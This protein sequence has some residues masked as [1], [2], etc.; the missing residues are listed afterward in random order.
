VPRERDPPGISALDP[1]PDASAA[2][3][4]QIFDLW[5]EPELQRRGVDMGRDGVRKALVV[6]APGRRVDVLINEEA[7]LVAHV[8]ATRP[9]EAGEPITTQDFDHVEGIQPFEVDPDAG[10]I[11]FAR[12]GQQVIIAFDFRRN[13]ARAGRLVERARE[14]ART[15]RL[16]HANGLLGPSIEAAYGAAELAVVGQMLLI[17]DDPPRDHPKRKRWFVGWTELGNAPQAHSRALTAL[18]KRR[19]AARYAETAIDMNDEKLREVLDV[20]DEMVEHAAAA[21]SPTGRGRQRAL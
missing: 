14:F 1:E 13:R 15:A 21:V 18:A 20:V 3:L 16:A 19:R 12:V 17:D 2:L 11:C 9:I 6:M 10:W 4:E 5:V 7:E 8:R